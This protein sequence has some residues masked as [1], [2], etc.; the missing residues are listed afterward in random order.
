MKSIRTALLLVAVA[1]PAVFV[2][3][4]FADPPPQPGK[5][6]QAV[7]AAKAPVI[8]GDLTDVAWTNA[9]EIT[10]FIQHDPNDETP[11]TEKTVVK[12]VYDDNAI[13]IGAHMIDSKPV[14]TLLG[15]RDN[16]LESDWFRVWIDA[17]HDK[18]SGA[19][20]WVNPSNV[21]VDMNLYNDIYDDWSWDAVWQSA[22]KVVPDGWVAEIK[23]PYSQLRFQQRDKQVWG[24]N[25]ARFIS[26]NQEVDR[27]VN[28]KKGDTGWVSRFADL[29]GIEGIKPERSLE[30]LPY[31]V[32][33]SDLANRISTGDPFTRPSS[34]GMDGGVDVKW[35]VS[36]TL[37]LTGT[38]NP[39]FGQVEVDPAVINLSD[40]E[41]F[42]P[43]KRPFFTEGAN[44]FSFGSG[45]ANWRANFNFFGPQLFYSRRI[46]RPPQGSVNADFVDSPTATTILGAA[47]LSGKIGNGWSVGVLDALTNSERARFAF[48]PGTALAA[49]ITSLRGTQPVEPLS[50]YIVARTT[51][52]YGNS[53][54]G[55][56]LTDVRRRVPEQLSSLRSNATVLGVDGYTLLHKKDWIFE[57]L[58]ATTKVDGSAEAIAD[59]QLS[60]AH[61]YQRPD[62]KQVRFD[63]TST[64]LS[65]FGGRAMLG[66]RTGR[67]RTNVQMSAYS[68]GYETNDVGYMPRA[69]AITS[70]AVLQ[71][72]HS[73]PTKHFR[74]WNWWVSKYQNWNWDHDKIA[75]GIFGNWY[76][77]FSNYW[78]I[79]GSGG[80]GFE[81]LSDR[82]TRG[83]P[84]AL[85]SPGWNVDLGFGSDSRKKVSVDSDVYLSAN[86]DS[87]YDRA[88][89]VSLAYRPLT[90]LTLRVGPYFERSFANSQYVSQVT[91]AAA[92]STYG[93]RY[94]F[95][96]LDQRQLQLETRADWTLNSRLSLQL[97]LQPFVASG[98]Y[99]DFK[100]LA[101][102]RTRDYAPTTYGRNPN[103]NF[104]SLRGS[105][106]A[107]WEFRPGSALYVVWNENRA[108]AQPFG[109]FRAR[110]DLT[111]LRD[112]RSKDVFLVKISYWLPM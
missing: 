25:F 40:T 88:L 67:W 21:Q 77:Q 3:T 42:F 35:A 47:K 24:I 26:R 41:T 109:D 96:G 14:T 54:I 10:D 73:E 28:V 22:A 33:R 52:E 23:I 94:I 18:L 68:P 58:A 1:V 11:P 65:G 72:V 99:H 38:V 8:D 112:A 69:D 106:V 44:I 79:Y 70:H 105:A 30:V 107:R 57:W 6:V 43:E 101:A 45:P 50:N 71:Y 5:T 62:L 7:R 63:P 64:S 81:V 84:L 93:R 108:D 39:D 91:D 75:D 20:F 59:T 34:Y 49:G 60:S 66:K 92:T 100:Q 2:P 78:Y 76:A 83:G 12:I 85:L 102:A 86:V 87:S 95:A 27:L 61:Y 16:N 13:Y 103:F 74:E 4:V 17:Q 89:R 97:Y 111:S 9:P 31:G 32:A 80:Y 37:R 56:I 36:S 15:R 48:T 98:D 110:R 90:S 51:K 29:T 46:G 82:K 19:G 53:R 104:R 55:M